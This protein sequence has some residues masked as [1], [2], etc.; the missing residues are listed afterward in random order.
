VAPG[1]AV[2]DMP[3]TPEGVCED[4]LEELEEEPDMASRPVPE[5]V[6]VE[7]AMIVAHA[8]SPSP[9]HGAATASSPAPRAATA[10]GIAVGVAV[11]PE[12]IMGH[13]TFYVSDDISLDEAV[14]TAHRA[15]SQVQRVLHREDE[16]LTN[17]SRRLQ[18]WATMLKETMVSERA[19]ARARQ[20]GFDL[21]VEAI[22]QSDANSKWA[23]LNVQ[24]LYVSAEACASIVI[25]QEED[26]T[27]RACQVNQWA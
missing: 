6:P 12:V 22:N 24:E 21:Q 5:E 3:Q 17:E 23:L 18:L 9:P 14:S 11:R 15:L 4:V 2:S 16:G 1:P 10:I 25:K 13:P 20:R 7:G 26:L 8:A 19:T 27:V